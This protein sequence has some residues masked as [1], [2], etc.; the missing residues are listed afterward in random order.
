MT[1]AVVTGCSSGFGV[2][3]ARGLAREGCT[4]VATMRN[5]GRAGAELRAESA[6]VRELDVTQQ[7]SRRALV[8][9]VLAEHGSIDVLVNN[10]GAVAVSSVED[11]DADVTALLFETN[12]FGPLELARA[13]LPGMR[14]R[15]TGRI[16]NITAM[17]ALISTPLLG[18]Y[19]ATKHALDSLTATLD[20]ECR[21]FGVRAASILPGHYRTSLVSN[22]RHVR[23]GDAYA[24]ISAALAADRERRAAD[25][26]EEYDAVVDAVRHAALDPDP[27][28]RYLAGRGL[29][30]TLEPVIDALGAVHAQD[31]AR[32]GVTHP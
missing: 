29:V 8:E 23:I 12:V 20:I 26:L 2:E 25:V 14:A 4:V 15:G 7:A 27:R 18:V 31:L 3:I 6:S 10:A 24:D 11:T 1:V 19:C 5:P 13:V 32:S 28:L 16:V 22:A 17:G 21:P 9:S 30:E